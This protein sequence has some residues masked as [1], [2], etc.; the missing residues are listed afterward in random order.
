M[1]IK[2]WKKVTNTKWIKKNIYLYIKEDEIS[3]FMISKGMGVKMW[4]VL[5]QVRGFPASILA[6]SFGDDATFTSKAEAIK[7]AKDYMRKH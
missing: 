5:I 6:M 1:A 4:N 2:D 3:N 7:Y